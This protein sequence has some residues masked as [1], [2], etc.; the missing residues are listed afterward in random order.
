M[1]L[2]ARDEPVG[3]KPLHSE[4]VAAGVLASGRKPVFL[5]VTSLLRLLYGRSEKCSS[6]S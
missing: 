1:Q 4:A 5:N 3:A 2:A 6:A